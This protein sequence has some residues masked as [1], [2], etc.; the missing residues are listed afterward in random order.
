MPLPSEL[1]WATLVSR[2]KCLSLGS[3]LIYSD[4]A[5]QMVHIIHRKEDYEKKILGRHV[6]RITMLR[7]VL[8]PI[9]LL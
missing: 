2:S 8:N 3:R 5:E 7:T 9:I 6:S 1:T 4:W